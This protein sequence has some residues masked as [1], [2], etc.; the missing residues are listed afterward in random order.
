MP[1]VRT[2]A[3]RWPGRENLY[4]EVSRRKRRKGLDSESLSKVT[5][6]SR[7][8]LSIRL[9]KEPGSWRLDE[10]DGLCR[11]LGISLVDGIKI[12]KGDETP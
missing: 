1:R 11:A 2:L 3:D 7:T 10:L 5:G 4:D 8:A 6:L 9:N 12:L